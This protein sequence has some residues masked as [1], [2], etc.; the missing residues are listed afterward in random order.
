MYIFYSA[1]NKTKPKA[2]HQKPMRQT[3][4]IKMQNRILQS[5]IFILKVFPPN[6]YY[7][8]RF[9]HLT[10]KNYNIKGNL[11]MKEGEFRKNICE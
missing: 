11:N 7:D 9:Y 5:E 3:H 4:S 6:D 2:I 1:H 10:P 8:I